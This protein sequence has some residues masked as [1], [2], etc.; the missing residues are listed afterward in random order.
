[1]QQTSSTLNET[2]LK[3]SMK[4]SFILLGI[5]AVLFA[6]CSHQY[7]VPVNH[8]VPMLDKKGD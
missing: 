2:K 8:N 6:S 7:Y 3:C 4:K 5:I 1:M